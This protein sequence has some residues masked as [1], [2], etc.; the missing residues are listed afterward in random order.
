MRLRS[1]LPQGCVAADQLQISVH[2]RLPCSVWSFMHVVHARPTARASGLRGR[3]LVQTSL[4]ISLRISLQISLDVSVCPLSFQ[5]SAHALL[6]HALG[7][8]REREKER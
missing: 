1:C 3:V 8:E 7:G 4:Q 6:Q 5:T 2:V